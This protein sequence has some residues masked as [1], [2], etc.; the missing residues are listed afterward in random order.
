MSGLKVKNKP[1]PWGFPG[2]SDSKEFVCNAGHLHPWVLKI[3][4]RREWHPTPVFLPGESHGQT[5]LVGYSPW[6]HK[7]LDTAKWLTLSFSIL[8]K[9][10]WIQWC[11]K[12][13][14]EGQRLYISSLCGFIPRPIH[15]HLYTF[16]RLILQKAGIYVHRNSNMTIVNINFLIQ[17]TWVP[18]TIVSF[19]TIYYH[20]L[21]FSICKKKVELD[22]RK[23]DFFQ[24]QNSVQ[25]RW[26]LCRGHLINS[27]LEKKFA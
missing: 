18:S 23:S 19:P 27:N 24:F 20:N 3:P 14:T 13:P 17:G 26:V 6:D 5:S 21:S 25:T 7:E 1:H 22:W 15:T 4:W 9:L 2:S 8:K 11:P 16:L 12:W 10:V